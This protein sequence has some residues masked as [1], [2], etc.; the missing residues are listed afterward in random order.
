MGVEMACE[1]ASEKAKGMEEQWALARDG[2]NV[3]FLLSCFLVPPRLGGRGVGEG[4][5]QLGQQGTAVA[6]ESADRG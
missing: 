1:S 4:E 3:Y 2:Q 5:A 6:R